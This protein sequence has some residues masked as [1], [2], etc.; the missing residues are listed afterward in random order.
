[1]RWGYTLDRV[2][3]KSISEEVTIGCRRMRGASQLEVWKTGSFR[4]KK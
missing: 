2:I 3:R 1:M 4:W